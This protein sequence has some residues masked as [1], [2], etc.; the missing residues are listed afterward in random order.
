MTNTKFDFGEVEKAMFEG[1]ECHLELIFGILAIPKSDLVEVE[2]TLFQG[3]A[4]HFHLI[5][6]HWTSL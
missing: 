4:W 1:L 6:G 3:L 5:F 2:K